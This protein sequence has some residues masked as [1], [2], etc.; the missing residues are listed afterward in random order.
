MQLCG[1]RA[2]GVLHRP[3]MRPAAAL[4]DGCAAGRVC[5]AV[6]HQDGQ[7]SSG[8]RWLCASAPLHADEKYTRMC[9]YDHAHAVCRGM[10]QWSWKAKHGVH[11][12]SQYIAYEMFSST[13]MEVDAESMKAVLVRGKVAGLGRSVM[14][15]F[16]C[17]QTGLYC[18]LTGQQHTSRTPA[19]SGLESAPRPTPSTPLM[20]SGQSAPPP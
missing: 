7:R 2:V 11:V 3:V 17:S 10:Q 6:G 20:L 4:Q 19:C 15:S 13:F 18:R 1:E 12:M 14:V 16:V 5:V 8:S 9:F